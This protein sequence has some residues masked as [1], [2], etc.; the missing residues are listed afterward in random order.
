[1]HDIFSARMTGEAVRQL[2]LLQQ[3][4][5]ENCWDHVTFV[6][7]KWPDEAIQV[8]L[9]LGTKES[10]LR[11]VFWRPMLR[12]KAKMFR[13]ENSRAS[14]ETI[15]RSLMYQT[16]VKFALQEEMDSG[17]T[18]AETAAGRFVIDTREQDERRHG[19]LKEALRPSGG[20]GPAACSGSGCADDDD[21]VESLYESIE[22]RKR[23]E[24]VLEEDVEAEVEKDMKTKLKNL[25]KNGKKPTVSTILSMLI[26]LSSFAINLAMALA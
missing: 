10:D 6:T 26:G 15:T 25:F 16:P 21:D 17:K 11:R 1:M 9:E 7:T 3:I 14:A 18:L 13:F 12:R 22:K 23:M 8:D 4:C 20:G 2:E 19:T 24:N 5:G